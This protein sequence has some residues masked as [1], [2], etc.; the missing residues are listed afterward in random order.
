MRSAPWW[1]AAI[2]VGLLAGI[3]LSSGAAASVTLTSQAFTPYR[4]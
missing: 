2:A 1:L 4:T 3:G